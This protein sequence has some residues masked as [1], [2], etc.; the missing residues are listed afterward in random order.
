[1]SVDEAIRIEIV[2]KKGVIHDKNESGILSEIE[3]FG[4]FGISHVEVVK[5]YSLF[6]L[7]NPSI[8]LPALKKDLFIEPIW[9]KELKHSNKD[10][11]RI[12][13]EIAPSPGVTNT[14]ID[15]ILRAVGE[16]GHKVVSASSS[17]KYIFSGFATDKQIAIIIDK[18]LSN[19]TIEYVVSD[20]IT[21]KQY[22]DSS[23]N[24]ELIPLRSYDRRNLNELSVRRQ[25]SLNDEE[26]ETIQE[27]F[28]KEQRDP[29]DCELET[30]A[31]TWSE[32]CFHKTFKSPLMIDGRKKLSLFGR[33]RK[34]TN[35]INHPDCLV[36][37]SDNAGIVSFDRSWALAAKTETH[38]S[39]SAIEP[40]G[41]AM[42]G[43]GGVFRDIA[44]AGLGAKNIAASDIFCLARPTLSH[45]SIPA[46]CLHPKRIMQKVIAG[47]QDYNNRMGIP[48]INGSLT[49]D[50]DYRAK[51]VVL[52]GGFGI[53]PKKY[54]HKRHS[55]R[56]DLII[57]VG[58]KTG[59][60]GIRG[61]TFSSISMT[62]DTEIVSS[63]AVQIGNP[64]EE[65]RMFD[66]LLEARDCGL[67][68]N[69][70]DC[71]GG[72][73][74][75]AIGEMAKE[76]GVVVNLSKVPLKYPGLSAWEMW[77]SESQER[78]VV[79]ISPKDR[80]KFI[81]I[82]DKYNTNATVIG[83][84][85]G[86][87]RLQVNFDG[88]NVADLPM[89]F[90]FEGIPLKM[91]HGKYSKSQNSISKPG[92]RTVPGQPT[93]KAKR[94]LKKVNYKHLLKRILA[95]P[96]VSSKE[97]IVRR[98][99]HEVQGRLALK[100]F[101][102]V[103]M[104][105]PQ[106]AAVIR[107]RFESPQGVAFGHGLAVGVSKFDP[108]LGA[109][110]AV[111]EAVRNVVCVGADPSKIFLLDNFIFPS[112]DAESLGDLD[113]AV[114][115][116]C[117]AAQAYNTPFISGKDSLSGTYK[118]KGITVKVPPTV[119]VS[120]MGIVH[121]IY[122]TVTSDFKESG[123]LVY[124]VGSLSNSLKGTIIDQLLKL[125]IDSSLRTRLRPNIKIYTSIH[126]VIQKGYIRA[127]H[128]ISDGGLAVTLSEMCIGGNCGVNI[129]LDKLT[130]KINPLAALFSESPGCM[131]LEVERER[132]SH[133]E[134]LITSSPHILLGKVTNR[135]F[136]S[137]TDKGHIVL[138]ESIT[139]LKKSWQMTFK[140]YF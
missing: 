115:G 69:I 86:T 78:M 122:E 52:V 79:V 42:T 76:I 50:L 57:S 15:S 136:L 46:G 24:V 17:K 37:F 5:V 138:E 95:H 105:G 13:V 47:V 30:I 41:G 139:A 77:L 12:L 32:H 65:R 8:A 66:A 83:K 44:A 63:G 124:L 97:E 127:C 80:S 43:S 100:P 94:K 33:I 90:L 112:V 11:K 92:S 35:E 40:Y 82:C 114:D 1:M 99:D 10:D 28:Q 118:G 98:Y 49:F 73:Y 131:V 21:R 19:K 96:S 75:S 74:S 140:R 102:G 6:G 27:H 34:V 71:G 85:T 70:A 7:E 128:D 126:K 117:T 93:D 2:S 103:Q 36:T 108:Y 3:D 88:L 22:L 48:T 59:R 81:R 64:I 135:A 87:K 38:N 55:Y 125:G 113:R 104:E 133:W 18:I 101:C 106:D 26:M 107:P 72:G 111:D 116:L 110:F 45:R 120:S 16:L 67:I 123:N 20:G 25:L 84:L 68:K 62:K 89:E 61:A 4:I 9:Q 130:K 129:S 60:D 134:R 132:K 109:I 51:P 58:G 23:G 56:G 91:L 53:L 137:I 119:I 31:Q 29:T 121:S 14:E 54:I 39:P